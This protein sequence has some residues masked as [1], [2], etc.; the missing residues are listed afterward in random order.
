VVSE[1]EHASFM[2]K[3]LAKH[4]PPRERFAAIARELVHSVFRPQPRPA[5]IHI[6]QELI[7]STYVS[8]LENVLGVTLLQ[9]LKARIEQTDFQPGLRPLHLEGLMYAL[10]LH[11]PAALPV[12]TLVDWA[13]FGSE[14]ESKRNARELERLVFDFTLPKPGSWYATL[15]DMKASGQITNAQFRGELTSILVSSYSV[16]SALSS[17]LLCLAARPDYVTKIRRQPRLARC[18]VNE[19]LRL[20]PP[21]RQFGY[22]RTDS[23]G[24]GATDF[25]VA[26]FALHRSA[27][28][29]NEP[30]RFKPER[31]LEVSVA[32]GSK[33]LPFGMGKRT[34]PGRSYSLN[35]M[36][37]VLLYVCAPHSLIS[38]QLPEDYRGTRG[39]FP[40]GASGRLISFPL[41]D[42]VT[43]VREAGAR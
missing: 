42:R 36:L 5:L 41:D 30:L 31:F 21:F 37:E 16:A 27:E 22:E 14:R 32:A 13:L 29:W 43:Y 10:G 20:Y 35:L 38:L 33:Y 18:F 12:R 39:R 23:L 19:V 26:V 4:W 34:C 1:D 9:P 40:I 17:M 2:R 6:S 8:L 11:L 24:A 7:R 28:A 25:M 3:A 15:L